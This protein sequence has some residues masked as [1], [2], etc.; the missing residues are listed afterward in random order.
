MSQSQITS[1]NVK[2]LIFDPE[3]PRLPTKLR[4]YSKDSEVLEW[5]ILYENILELMGSI[6]V[7][8]YFPAEPLL[9]VKSTRKP[10]Y[11]VIE[12]NRRLA[13]VKLLNQPSL[14]TTKR[15]SIDELATEAVYR[16]ASLPSIIFDKREDILVYLGYRHI[17]GIKEW[18]PL[19][20]AKYLDAL[21][22]T[23][24][25]RN[26]EEEYRTLAKI[27]GSKVTF[28]RNILAGL[29]VYNEIEGNSFFGIAGLDEISVEFG[30]LYTAVSRR[31]IATFVGVDIDADNPT[32]HVKVK[33]LRELTSWMFEKSSEG[34]TRLGESR[35]LTDLD[36]V[37]ANSMALK[38]F[39]QGRPLSEAVLYTGKP[40]MILNQ[41]INNSLS[42]LK[43]AQDQLHH[44]D[45]PD[46]DILI[47]LDDLTRLASDLK[48]L[49]KAKQDTNQ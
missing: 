6:G 39:R 17:T 5:M 41:S 37:V 18:G 13:A 43:V 47:I 7:K 19:A 24:K 42:S 30:V 32:K 46:S 35:N 12:G 20:K 22:K 27:I 45:R 33:Q 49:I 26:R 9:V 36:E 15:N 44:I 34:V 31:N 40:A 3:N 8:G 25:I 48:K 23:L 16:P 14:A 10:G 4:G 2:D 21:R 1:L 28:V 38:Y 11:E 29:Q